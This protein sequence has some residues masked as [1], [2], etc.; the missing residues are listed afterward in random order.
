M[1]AQNPMDRKYYY[2]VDKCMPFGAAISCSHFQRFSD[3]VAHIVKFFTKKENI[4]YLDDFF[5]AALLKAVCDGQIKMFLKVCQTINF[6]VS[7]EKTFWGTTKLTFLGLLI[8]TVAQLVCI[9]TDKIE[10]AIDLLSTILSKRSKK[11]TLNQLQKVT[12]FLNFLCKA[13][14]PGRAFTR[15]LYFIEERALNKNLKK[16]HHINITAEMRMDMELWLEFFPPSYC[17]C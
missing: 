17:L 15:R 14:I 16:H 1:A 4:N 3:A 7:M 11:L 5:F 10:K 9:P 2:F 6:P 12:G 8:D 13:V